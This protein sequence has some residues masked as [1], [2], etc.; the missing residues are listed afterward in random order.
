MSSA[1]PA[2]TPADAATY[3]SHFEHTALFEFS[4]VINSSLDLKFILSHILLT[5]MGKLLSSKGMV[6]L[7]KEKS[8][9]RVE[10]IKG[11]GGTLLGRE[12]TIARIPESLFHVEK[13]RGAKETW[14]TPLQEM[15][16]HI[17]LPLS[18]AE[19]PIGLLCFGERFSGKKLTLMEETYLRS[20]A[21][22][23][24]TA[25]EKS[26]TVGEIELV[27]RKL[28]RKIQELNTLF[29]LGKEFG[30]L[31]DPDR[32][33]RLL[34][35]SLQGQIGVSRYL[36]CLR[37]HADMKVT[38][39]RL[40]GPAPQGELLMKLSDLKSAVRVD[41][42]V[43]KHAVNIREILGALG[44]RVIVPMQ[45]QGEV[46]GIV[47][48]GEKLTRE[49]F[50]DADLEFLS[51]LVNLASISLENARL[52]REAIEKQRM[53]DELLIAR[54]IQ[55]GLLPNVIPTI[56]GFDLAASNISSKQVGGDY[57]D[58]L[59]IG[60][61]KFIIAIGDVSGKGTPAALLMAN[62]QATIRALAPFDLSL[63]EF[64][65]RVNDLMCRNTGGYKFITFFWGIINE[66]DRSLTYVNAGHNYPMLLRKDGTV[67]RLDKGGMILGVMPALAP[68]EQ[69]TVSFHSGDLLVL[70]TDG[71]S[72]AMSKES[73]EYEES[74]L[75]EYLPTIR[76]LSAEEIVEAIYQ[77]VLRHTRGA[78][79]SDDITMMVVKVS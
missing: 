48:L 7:K 62:L 18:I 36:I 20:L 15:G 17:V 79:Q 75:E 33:V 39:S 9:Y 38:A 56:Q 5:L 45:I 37:D 14:F 11:F 55:K 51:S 13:E 59:P 27:N 70:F 26:R 44:L 60:G 35:L 1:K 49:P 42:L 54:D 24:A 29:E 67:V 72:E 50:S 16:V 46:K 25:I 58:V 8:V 68:Y 19:K 61:D 71:V 21:N 69:E 23:S 3:E 12:M 53:E 40:D 52:F 65:G 32:L 77:D 41:D 74:H 63:N 22:I 34:V 28:D 76:H 47:L 30:V 78:S 4:K 6:L 73:V 10:A 64:T 66:R 43:V 57:Y 31:L 2:R